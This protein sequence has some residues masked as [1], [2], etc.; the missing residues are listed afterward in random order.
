MAQADLLRVASAAQ[1]A[2]K[3]KTEAEQARQELRDTILAARASGESY[4]GIAQAAG[5]SHPYIVK[6]VKESA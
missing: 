3:A 5:V 1:R 4:R 2:E 6:I